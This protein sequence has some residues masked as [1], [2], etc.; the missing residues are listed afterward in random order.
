MATPRAICFDL[1]GTLFD[2]QGSARVGVTRFLQGFGVE[3][4]EAAIRAWFTAEDEQFERWRSGAISFREQRRGRLRTVLPHLG[5][6]VP[7]DDAALDAVF[8]D[9]LRSYRE[10]WRLFPE[11]LPLLHELR[12]HGHRLGLLTNGTESQQLDKLARTGLADAFDVVCISERIGFQKPDVR[13]F[14]TLAAQ[15]G[16]DPTDCLFVGD[17]PERDVAGARAAGMRAV[18]VDQ[19]QPE[20]PGLR[21]VVLSAR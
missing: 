17:D 10:A 5:V 19:A 6:E 14:H 1:D 4:T 21:A 13:A 7:G 12:E 15:L 18:L 2:H 9:Y 20:T 3:P 16:L 8:D 11:S